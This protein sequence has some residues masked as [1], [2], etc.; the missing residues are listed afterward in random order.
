MCSY[1]VGVTL[2]MDLDVFWP[3]LSFMASRRENTGIFL[4]V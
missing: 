3:V 2:Q 4:V 1:S